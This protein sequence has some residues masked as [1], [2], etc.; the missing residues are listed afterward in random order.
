MKRGLKTFARSI[1]SND[2]DKVQEMYDKIVQG[3]MDDEVWEGYHMALEGMVES[4]ESGE[5]LTLPR[6]IANDKY[7]KDRLE[8][9]SKEMENRATQ[10]FRTPQEKGF[11]KAWADV[12]KVIT[13]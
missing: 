6:Q 3:N 1:R 12:L 8:E 10:E 11:N 4:L 5:E 2:L 9:I 13:E 7:S